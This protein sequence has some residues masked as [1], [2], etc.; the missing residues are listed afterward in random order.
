M[1]KDNANY[2]ESLFAHQYEVTWIAPPDNGEPIED[3]D[4]RCCEL[5]RI[6]DKF[7]VLD[8]TCRNEPL[9]GIRTKHFLRN[10]KPNTFYR[11]DVRAR[12]IIGYGEPGFVKF[13]TAA[14]ESQY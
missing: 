2:D 14:G 4:I 10:L 8:G 1:R 12:N 3:Y 5:T 6:D 7:E 9:K 13:K 11:A